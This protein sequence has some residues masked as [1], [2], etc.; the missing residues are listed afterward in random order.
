MQPIFSVG[1]HYRPYGL[2]QRRFV[3]RSNVK[4][5]NDSFAVDNQQG[6]NG[7]HPVGSM[8]CRSLSINTGRCAGQF[9]GG[10][11][12]GGAP[13]TVSTIHPLNLLADYRLSSDGSDAA[14]RTMASAL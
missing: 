3:S 4:F 6:R 14:G 13:V 9:A 5:A 8:T 11:F 12:A 10:E 2:S 1:F 7:R